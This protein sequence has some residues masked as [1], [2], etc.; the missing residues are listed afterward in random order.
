MLFEA[1][2]QAMT[3]HL[4]FRGYVLVAAFVLAI[5]PN[6]LLRGPANRIVRLWRNI[7]APVALADPHKEREKQ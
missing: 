2:Y 5:L 1:I 4:D 7:S 3:H 6:L